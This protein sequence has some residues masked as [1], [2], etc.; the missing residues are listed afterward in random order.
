[1]LTWKIKCLSYH[2]FAMKSS[3]ES[4]DQ[5]VSYSHIGDQKVVKAKDD[6]THCPLIFMAVLLDVCFYH[7]Y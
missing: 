1:M 4:P 3:C 2:V 6:L 5:V 7:I